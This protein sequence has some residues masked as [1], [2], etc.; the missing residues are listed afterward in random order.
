MI[1][2]YNIFTTCYSI[3]LSNSKANNRVSCKQ[4]LHWSS[5]RE[6]ESLLLFK[7]ILRLFL[8]LIYFF[9]VII[10][11]HQRN[12]RSSAPFLPSHQRVIITIL[13]FLS[14]SLTGWPAL[15]Y[16]VNGLQAG[17]KWPIGSLLSVIKRENSQQGG[18]WCLLTQSC[19]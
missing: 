8:L 9:I 12:V 5:L 4:S 17:T 16:T 18:H 6:E 11:Q 13:L 15:K 10:R 1:I 3:I 7:E 14:S 19:L 2:L